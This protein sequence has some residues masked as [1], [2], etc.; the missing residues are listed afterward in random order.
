MLATD[1]SRLSPTTFTVQDGATVPVVSP[2][3]GITTA[4]AFT[5]PPNALA[6]I[7]QASAACRYGNNSYLDGSAANKGYKSGQALSDISVPCFSGQTIYIAAE[8]GT[9][10]VDF[11]FEMM[12]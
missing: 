3:T 12:G 8:T 9:I 1:A 2:K 11:M 5:P 10:A 7:F 4:Q 6:M